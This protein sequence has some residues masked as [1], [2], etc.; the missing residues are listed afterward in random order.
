M[1]EPDRAP[2]PIPPFDPAAW[3]HQMSYR[4]D[5]ELPFDPALVPHGTA[6][7]PDSCF[8]IDALKGLVPSGVAALVRMPTRPLLHSTVCRAELTA[9]SAKLPPADPRTPAS[10]ARILSM[11]ARMPSERFV[12]PSAAGWDEEGEIGR[13][14]V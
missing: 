8:Y 4:P 14:H 1:S 12:Q 2:P 9:G 7:L 5:A 13:A 11:L 10:R 6:L 3:S